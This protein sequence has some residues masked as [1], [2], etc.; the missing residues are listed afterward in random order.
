MK[1]QY[2]AGPC[3]HKQCCPQG[4]THQKIVE[5]NKGPRFERGGDPQEC[6][7]ELGKKLIADH[8]GMFEESRKTS[9]KKATPVTK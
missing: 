4:D 6:S 3:K 2:K 9:A 1:I 5:V 7:D 8:P